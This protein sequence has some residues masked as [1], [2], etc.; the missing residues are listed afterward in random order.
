[1]SRF[2][3]AM[4]KVVTEE[5]RRRQVE[6]KQ[7]QSHEVSTARGVSVGGT[8]RVKHK[9]IV[10]SPIIPLARALESCGGLE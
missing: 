6:F 7:V 4:G 10:T 3:N 5:R 8:A 2:S 1:M 9:A